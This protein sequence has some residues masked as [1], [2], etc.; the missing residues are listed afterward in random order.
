[1]TDDP[2]RH[3]VLVGLMGAGKTT[4]GERCAQRLDRPFVDTDDLVQTLAGRPVA[5]VFATD[6]EAGFRALERHAVADACASPVPLVIACGGGAVLDP[7]SRRRLHTAGFVVWLRARPDVLA[8]RVDAEDLERPLLAGGSLPTL[9]RLAT[10]RAPVYE[11]VAD[12]TVAT[13]DRTPDEVATV[14]LEELAR[15]AA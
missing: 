10:T 4:V 5:E 9:E 7:D 8:G 13:D 3:L 6:G 12:A 14:V 11:T 15:C 1:M 2:R